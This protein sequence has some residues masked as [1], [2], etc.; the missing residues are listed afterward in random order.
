MKN[1][2]VILIPALDPPASFKIYLKELIEAGFEKIIVVDDGSAEKNLFHEVE[3]YPQITVLTHERNFGKGKALR[4]GMQYYKNH[5]IDQHY[6]GIITA[7]SDG[8]HL[9]KDVIK[10]AQELEKCSDNL[11]LG[12]RDFNQD[13]VPFKSRF[14]NKIT[15]LFFRLIVGVAVSD[16][17][18]GLRGIP[19]SMIDMC[20]G[21]EGDRFEYETAMLMEAA[22]E[23]KIQEETIHTV[24]YE[25]N[26]GSHFHPVKDSLR[27]YRLLFQTFF[28]YLL[29]SLSSFLIDITLFALFSKVI[30]P[31]FSEKIIVST[32]LARILSGIYNF[33][34]NKNVVFKSNR[35]YSSTALQYLAL[36]IIQMSCS[37]LLV[38]ITTI[39]TRLDEVVMKMIVDSL[40]FIASYAIQKT[41]I[42]KN[43]N[44][45]EQKNN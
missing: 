35:S 5:F 42:F 38:K 31:E 6:C 4:T 18:A 40:L 12:V 8:Q 36:Y 10:I 15:S 33:I 26:K 20:L 32:I 27:I 25:N 28:K 43:R 44:R 37:A 19:N 23:H 30:L 2:C 14:G 45:Y 9:C 16:T 41:I 7:D 3:K 21:I 1:H 13:I 22:R 39:I 24:Y 17:Q 29:V 11:I 34:M